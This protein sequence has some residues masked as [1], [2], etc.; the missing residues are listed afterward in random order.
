MFAMTKQCLQKWVVSK[1]QPEKFVYERDLHSLIRDSIARDIDNLEFPPNVQLLDMDYAKDNKLVVLVSF[2]IEEELAHFAMIILD[3]DGVEVRIEE[4]KPLTYKAQEFDPNSVSLSLSNGGPT[5]FIFFP[6]AIIMTTIARGI[7]YDEVLPLQNDRILG[8]GVDRTKAWDREHENTSRAVVFC[9]NTGIIGVDLNLHG[10]LAGRSDESAGS[11]GEYAGQQDKMTEQLKAKLEQAV[12]FA[13]L[14]EYHANPISFDMPEINGNMDEA[15]MD[16]STAIV[17]SGTKHIP[18]VLEV[19][20]QLSEKL[21]R[22]NQIIRYIT[23]NMALDK[24]SIPTRHKLCSNAEKVSAAL[25]LWHYQNSL[26]A[27][28]GE[29]KEPHARILS[30]AIEQFMT[31][32]NQ[33]EDVVRS[34]FRNHISFIGELLEYVQRL[35]QNIISISRSHAFSKEV[36]LYE[37]NKIFLIVLKSAETYRTEHAEVYGLVEV[38]PTEPWTS[39]KTL[40]DL[41]QTQCEHTQN[42]LRQGSGE[43]DIM[44]GIGGVGSRSSQSKDRTSLYDFGDD[45][46]MMLSGAGGMATSGGD[47]LAA[48]SGVPLRDM[49]KTQ[50]CHLT[51]ILL[52]TFEERIRFLAS[53]NKTAVVEREVQTLQGQFN[54]ARPRFILP[55]VPLGRRDDAF[56]LAEKY[57]DFETL[58]ELSL[59]ESP[60]EQADRLR[61]YIEKFQGD[62]A[63]VLYRTYLRKGSLRKLFEQPESYDDMVNSFLSDAKIPWL[64]WIQ[65]IRSE[66]YENASNKLWD[67]AKTEASVARQ[68]TAFNLSKLSF[69][70]SVPL[71]LM[72]DQHVSS[73]L[74]EYNVLSELMSL[75]EHLKSTFDDIV[76]QGTR[77]SSTDGSPDMETR[78]NIISSVFYS[79]LEAEHPGL[80]FLCRHLVRQVL[81]E[82]SLDPENMIELLT[83]GPKDENVMWLVSAMEVVIK[84]SKEIPEDR[85]S[86]TVSTIW[87]RAWLHSSWGRIAE[88]AKSSAD[89]VGVDQLKT[90]A[91]FAILTNTNAEAPFPSQIAFNID[92]NTIK[93]RFPQ[94]SSEQIEQLHKDLT[95]EAKL[96]QDGVANYYLDDVLTECMR[97]R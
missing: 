27:R 68:K 5:A 87:T 70:A 63:N 48:E 15:A 57:Q 14:D 62:F 8:F 82:R 71:E 59:R 67:T 26:L 76:A 52:G 38:P 7:N 78:V 16:L 83:L 84:A 61:Y 58:V 1:S 35:V 49:M 60:E 93:S 65:D 97:L 9:S 20:Y 86:Q 85:L 50:L 6:D 17:E 12:F 42:L 46:V 25:N 31:A 80:W 37:A 56:R 96:L 95:A 29:S 33:S 45:D 4:K 23:I 22:L 11:Y 41:L 81:E 40:L 34:F 90:T 32:H 74:Q 64:S 89:E 55:L 18:A 75:Q 73:R 13:S 72:E 53:A 88:I 91:V 77:L 2:T 79:H 3:V 39:T 24:I 44:V 19:K 21:N 30:D 10:I 54:V 43:D 94:L 47:P 36:A 92:Q 66:L 69:L 28:S 51:D